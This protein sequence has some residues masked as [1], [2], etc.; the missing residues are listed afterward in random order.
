MAIKNPDQFNDRSFKVAPLIFNPPIPKICDKMWHVIVFLAYF[1][2]IVYT[3]G[4]NEIGNLCN[5]RYLKNPFEQ[6]GVQ[7][8]GGSNPLTPTK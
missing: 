6:N 8:V 2:S 5:Y 1:A 3:L 7:G 4:P